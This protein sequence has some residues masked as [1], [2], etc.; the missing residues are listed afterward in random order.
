MSYKTFV[1]PV[2]KELTLF[3]KLLD[4]YGSKKA[5]IREED[6]REL[7]LV[8]PRGVMGDIELHAHFSKNGLSSQVMVIGDI[9]AIEHTKLHLETLIKGKLQPAL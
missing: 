4:W 6:E 3:G 1:V 8:Y 5:K 9:S 2:E 7:L